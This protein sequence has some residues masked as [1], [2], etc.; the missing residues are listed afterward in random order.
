MVAALEGAQAIST[1]SKPV[2]GKPLA[3]ENYIIA[4]RR[5]SPTLLKEINALLDA[6]R[7]DGKLEEMQ[8]ENF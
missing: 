7:R 3:D 4:V 2:V 6:L 5:D 8:K 1:R